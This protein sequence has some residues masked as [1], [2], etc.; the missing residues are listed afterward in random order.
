MDLD[1][2]TEWLIQSL[3]VL[4]REEIPH[5]GLLDTTN[6]LKYLRETFADTMSLSALLETF[7]SR[8]QTGEGLLNYSNSLE[9]LYRRINQHSPNTL[10]YSALC[11]RL[12]NRIRKKDF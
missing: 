11:N 4:A 7:H 6:I 12:V 3:A 10:S 8:R 5:M 1:A 9:Q 2:A